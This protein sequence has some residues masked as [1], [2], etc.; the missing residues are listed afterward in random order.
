MEEVTEKLSGSETASSQANRKHGEGKFTFEDGSVYDGLFVDDRM[1]EVK[2]ATRIRALSTC[3]RM[4]TY[5]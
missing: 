4:G 3:A 5:Y 1:A 2:L